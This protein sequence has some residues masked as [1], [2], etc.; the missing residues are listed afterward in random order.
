MPEANNLLALREAGQSI[1][2]D[3][4]RRGGSPAG[5]WPGPIRD[6]GV[7][8]VT[9]NPTIFARAIGDTSDYDDAIGCIAIQGRTNP[10]DDVRMAAD[11]FR[12]IYE[13]TGGA[14]GFVSSELEVRLAHSRRDVEGHEEWTDATV[15]KTIEGRLEQASTP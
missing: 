8:G 3:F 9:S 14:D 4:V 13:E 15:V 2:F 11:L 6:D 7:T 1:W 10:L 12:P 5:V